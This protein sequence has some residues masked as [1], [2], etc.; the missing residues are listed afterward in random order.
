MKFVKTQDVIEVEVTGHFR[1]ANFDTK[2][3][4]LTPF[5]II[6]CILDNADVKRTTMRELRV[7]KM[8]K[9]EN[10][11]QLRWVSFSV[12]DLIAN[13]KLWVL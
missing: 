6:T 8:L 10:I 12:A 4:Y 7:L 3:I 2:I 11:V 13:G 1:N 5:V 9:Q